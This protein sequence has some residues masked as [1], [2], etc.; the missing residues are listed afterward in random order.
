V[1]RALRR[2]AIWAAAF[3]LL[4]LLF[5]NIKPAPAETEIS[6]RSFKTALREGGVAAVDRGPEMIRGTMKSGGVLLRFR[7]RPFPDPNLDEEL[8]TRHVP[9]VA[10]SPG[11]SF[12][13]KLM[14]DVGGIALFFALYWLYII[15]KRKPREPFS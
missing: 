6:Y 8:M 7:T 3:V 4:T 15:N 2:L 14:L 10:N 11:L 5:H 1:N 9:S 12:G 13:A